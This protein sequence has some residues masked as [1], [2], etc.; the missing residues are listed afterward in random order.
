MYRVEGA[1]ISGAMIGGEG[2]E[3]GVERTPHSALRATFSHKGEGEADR[4]T[5]FPPMPS[6]TDLRAAELPFWLH[7]YN[8]TGRTA[9]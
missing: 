1:W 8:G 3:C 5:G 9:A 6:P 7:R 2:W 4:E